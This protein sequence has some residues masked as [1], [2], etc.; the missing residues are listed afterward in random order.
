MA[1]GTSPFFVILT[2]CILVEICG[3]S[4]RI[5]SWNAGIMFLRNVG[6]FMPPYMASHSKRRLSYFGGYM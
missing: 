4:W 1:M 3:H 2:P 5:K 6:T